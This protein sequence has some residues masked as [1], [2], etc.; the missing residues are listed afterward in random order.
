[1]S[2][3]PQLSKRLIMSAVLALSLGAAS[4]ASAAPAAAS[5]GTVPVCSGAKE[6]VVDVTQDVRDQP[7]LPARDGH[8]WATFDYT[9]HLRIWSVGTRQYCVR[10]DYEGTWD[11]VAG[12]SPGLSGTISDGVTGTFHGA[13]LWSWTGELAPDA[14]TSGHLGEVQAGCTDVDECAD[15]SYLIVNKLYFPQGWAH[16]RIVRGS[17]HVDGGSHGHLTVTVDGTPR[18]VQGVGD[19]TG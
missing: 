1:M 2:D 15:D 8:M 19:I 7:L 3:F 14:P 10:K 9:Q 11:S 12:L 16:C 6:L 4:V 5:S 18:G 17:I 13:E